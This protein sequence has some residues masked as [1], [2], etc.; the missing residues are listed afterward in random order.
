MH[1]VLSSHNVFC[2]L[3]YILKTPGMSIAC[4]FSKLSIVTKVI[5]FCKHNNESIYFS[6]LPPN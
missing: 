2:K 6:D 1:K 5:T 4:I 3:V